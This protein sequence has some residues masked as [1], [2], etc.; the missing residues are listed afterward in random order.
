M[1][2]LCVDLRITKYTFK[3]YGVKV[4]IGQD[5]VQWQSYVIMVRN[6]WLHAKMKRNFSTSSATISFS[7]VVGQFGSTDSDQR[8][9]DRDR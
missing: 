1:E 3:K 5:K 9:H 4:W 7:H 2:D 6:I 8:A